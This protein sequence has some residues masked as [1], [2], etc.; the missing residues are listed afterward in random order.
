LRGR[1]LDD[2][3][4]NQAQQPVQYQRNRDDAQ[5]VQAVSQREFRP[6]RKSPGIGHK[7]YR[8]ASITLELRTSCS[9]QRFGVRASRMKGGPG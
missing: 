5:H 4:R 7:L 9:R 3:I 1:A 2:Q 6:V 8:R